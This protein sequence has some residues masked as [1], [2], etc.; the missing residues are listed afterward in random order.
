MYL[1]VE[2][3][4]FTLDGT[5][6]HEQRHVSAFISDVKSLIMP[7]LAKIDALR[8]ESSAYFDNQLSKYERQLLQKLFE[9]K[10]RGLNHEPPHPRAGT[11]YPPLGER[12][13]NPMD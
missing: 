5:Y 8:N 10:R 1:N 7:E 11:E 2:D 4:P 9:A 13:T 12:P 6:G 3:N